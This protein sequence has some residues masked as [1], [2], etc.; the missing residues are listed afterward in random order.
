MAMT[1]TATSI[2]TMV[3]ARREA[4]ERGG[5]MGARGAG[6]VISPDLGMRTFLVHRS[7]LLADLT[8]AFA[9]K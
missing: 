2:S 3:M 6:E 4:W 5:S 9:I 1:P 7:D 8:G